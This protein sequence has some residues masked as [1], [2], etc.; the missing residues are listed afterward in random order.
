MTYQGDDTQQ[1]TLFKIFAFLFTL[2]W[3][4]PCFGW[5]I[6][7]LGGPIFFQNVLTKQTEN[8]ISVKA[9]VVDYEYEGK[10]S[11][12]KY[13]AEYDVKG[14]KYRITSNTST[15]ISALQKK[16]GEEVLVKYNPQHPEDSILEEE[17]SGSFNLIFFIIGTIS[18][19]L[20]ILS[21]IGLLFIKN[22]IYS[23]T[24]YYIQR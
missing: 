18:I 4:L 1:K 17:I 10:N 3:I 11:L 7:T 16:Y 21:V 6:V 2:F 9:K 14:H 12:K 24:E 23:S 19:V 13:V 8:Y 22:K 20:G 5:G 15:N